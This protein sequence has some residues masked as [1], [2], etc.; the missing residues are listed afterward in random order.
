[1]STALGLPLYTIRYLWLWAVVINDTN[2]KLPTVSPS[3]V[4][5]RLHPARHWAHPGLSE[6]QGA[7]EKTC[8]PLQALSASSVLMETMDVLMPRSK[9]LKFFSLFRKGKR[10]VV[11]RGAGGVGGT[12]G[13]GGTGGAGGTKGTG[14]NGGAGGT[15][16]AGGTGGTG[17]T[18]GAGGTEGAGGAGGF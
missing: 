7:Q 8:L 12:K 6:R 17:G 16:G 1:M 15:V 4:T 9:S 3:C 14:G 18:G 11:K 10:M 5:H 2:F 13:T